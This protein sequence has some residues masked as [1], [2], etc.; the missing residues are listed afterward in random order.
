MDN[1]I[2]AISVRASKLE[3]SIKEKHSGMLYIGLCRLF[4]TILA[5]HRAKIGGRYHLVVLALQGLLRCLFVPYT[6]HEPNGEE[7]SAFGVAHTVAYARILTSI[8]DP[9]VSS[10]TRSKR[11]SGLELNDATKKARSIA[12]QHLPYLMMEYCSCQLKGRLTPE[13]KTT[14]NPGLDAVLGIL[15][16]EMMRTMNAAMDSSSRSVFKALYEE[17]RRIGRWDGD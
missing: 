13:M 1:L 9:T 10:V 4:G 14:L 3:A 8:C 15:S 7:I 16:P 5:A 6:N 2:S 11:R 12:G 17:Y